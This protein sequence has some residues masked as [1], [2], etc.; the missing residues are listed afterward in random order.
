MSQSLQLLLL[1]LLLP[2]SQCCYCCCVFFGV[3]FSTLNIPVLSSLL[4][5]MVLAPI[6]AAMMY[7]PSMGTE[8]A[9]YIR[10][11]NDGLYR[12]LTYLLFKLLD[13]LLLMAPVTAGTTA[14][15]F[16]ACKL[17]GSYLLFWLVHYAT[18]ANG[19]GKIDANFVSDKPACWLKCLNRKADSC[20]SN[21]EMMEEQMPCM[22]TW[23]SLAAVYRVYVV[24]FLAAA[25]AY[26]LASISPSIMVAMPL[27]SFVLVLALIVCGFMIR[28]A[29][30]PSYW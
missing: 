5:L 19:T 23:S 1:P 4:F 28:V 3:D 30:M 2:S 26:F 12:P 10:E 24:C 8:R 27:L 18:L 9:L 17:Q 22:Y 21:H 11:R 25:L 15:V 6:C 20:S 7:L 13:E 29:V 14:A 16:H